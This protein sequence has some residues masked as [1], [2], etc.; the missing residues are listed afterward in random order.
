MDQELEAHRRRAHAAGAGVPERLALLHALRR[1][2]RPLAEAW[3][4]LVGPLQIELSPGPDVDEALRELAGLDPNRLWRHPQDW[5][6]LCRVGASLLTAHMDTSLNPPTLVVSIEET[7]GEDFEDYDQHR[8]RWHIEHPP[9]AV[10]LAAWDRRLVVADED[11]WVREGGL[12]ELNANRPRWRR[13]V[14]GALAVGYLRDGTLGVVGARLWHLQPATGEVL[15]EHPLPLQR[16]PTV[17]LVDPRGYVAASDGTGVWLVNVAAGSARLLLEDAARVVD[18]SVTRL[19][20]GRER[21]AIL[22]NDVAEWHIERRELHRK[23]ERPRRIR[24]W[25]D[26]ESTMGMGRDVRE[27]EEVGRAF[28]DVLYLGK[29]ALALCDGEGRVQFKGRTVLRDVHSL[30]VVAGGTARGVMA[31]TDKE[32]PV[33][34]VF[35][36]REM[37][38]RLPSRATAIANGKRHLFVGLENGRVA[39]FDARTGE[40]RQ[41]VSL[42]AG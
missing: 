19:A 22:G 31:D 14:P 32:R 20:L 24:R 23:H 41:P 7:P 17:A 38:L 36:D 2:G 8:Y 28:R 6:D 1:A 35:G 30:G 39:W 33:L 21:V 26:P 11:G 25:E 4:D 9:A 37:T 16:S 42:G 15:A 40:E 18:G 34:R 3:T 13:R 10:A 5:V 27:Y 12:R 29:D